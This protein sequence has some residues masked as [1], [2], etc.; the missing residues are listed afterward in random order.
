MRRAWGKQRVK[1]GRE[2][3]KSHPDEKTGCPNRFNLTLGTKAGGKTKVFWERILRVS[4]ARS[5]VG[6][7][8]CFLSC[9]TQTLDHSFLPTLSFSDM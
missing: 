5:C 7:F 8:V 2:A 1:V 3:E 9:P 6:C 4:G